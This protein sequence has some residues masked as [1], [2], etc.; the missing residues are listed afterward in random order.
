VKDNFNCTKT[1]SSSV[2]VSSSASADF[3]ANPA[4]GVVPLVVNFIYTGSG[5]NSYIWNFGDGTTGTGLNPSHTY[6]LDG[7]YTVILSVNSGPPDFCTDTFSVLIKAIL[8]SSLIVPNV[9]TPNGDGVNDLFK[10]VEVALE[11]MHI[12]IYNRWGE[13][14][15][16][17]NNPNGSW[18]GN[19]KNGQNC[20]DGTY[21][22]ILEAKGFD[23]IEYN[24]N[25]N[26]TLIR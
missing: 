23:L 17:W 6:T 11:T 3:I 1:E 7:S 24:K 25:G 5:A 21:F 13:K 9:F 22:Y 16:E 20:A 4:S 15:S 18:D 8:P 19:N 2:F 12:I 10:P 14:V 26:I